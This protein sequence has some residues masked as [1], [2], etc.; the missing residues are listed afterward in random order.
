MNKV[1]KDSLRKKYR[2]KRS[3]L[4]YAQTDSSSSIIIEK[5]KE[6]IVTRKSCKKVF[7][8]RE[9]DN[10]VIVSRLIPFLHRRSIEVYVPIAVNGTWKVALTTEDTKWSKDK[11]GILFPV[12]PIKTYG[13]LLEAQFRK[14][15]VA[16]IPGLAFSIKGGRLGYGKGI[17]DRLI[18]NLPSLKLGV[19]YDFQITRSLPLEPHDIPMDMIITDNTD[20]RFI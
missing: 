20:F 10:E 17:Y 15:D 18:L 14:D 2:K 12:N 11:S 16:I 1:T 13:T 4:S 3:L 6:V 19:C 7:L 9:F 5:L 8:Y